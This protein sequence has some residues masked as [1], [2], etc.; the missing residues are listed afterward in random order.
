M[1]DK[2]VDTEARALE[3]RLASVTRERDALLAAMD[4]D[5]DVLALR[6]TIASARAICLETELQR[7]LAERKR[8]RTTIEYLESCLTGWKRMEAEA[9]A[10][11]ASVYRRLEAAEAERDKLRRAADGHARE[12]VA[13]V[14][15]ALADL[16]EAQRECETLR[17]RHRAFAESVEELRAGVAT[18][19]DC[20]GNMTPVVTNGCDICSAKYQAEYEARGRANDAFETRVNALRAALAKVRD[21]TT[22]VCV[23]GDPAAC[24]AD[25][26]APC[27]HCVAAAALAADTAGTLER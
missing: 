10:R 17:A 8:A 6:D 14:R 5:R 25:G 11:E 24:V 22:M 19:Q 27:S 20:F 23:V 18:C 7:E 12:L 16:D 13:A 1:T 15:S 4:Y 9:C 21:V 3:D 2:H 26:D